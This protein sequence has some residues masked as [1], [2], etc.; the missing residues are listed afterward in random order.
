MLLKPM[1]EIFDLLDRP[2]AN[3]EAVAAY[4]RA[5]NPNIAIEVKT[6]SAEK[7]S[8]DF[9]R[10]TI[11]GTNGE[12][13]G[14]DAPTFGIIGRLGGIGARPGVTGFVSDGDGAL[15]ALT[16]AAKLSDMAAKGDR[17]PGDVRIATH[18]CPNAPIIPHD[19]VPFMGSPVGM[20]IMNR[21]EIFGRMDAI[22]AIDTTRGNRIINHRGIAISNTVKSGYILKVSDDLVRI[23]EITTGELAHVFPLATQDI[24]PYGNGLTH[25]NSIL[26]PATATDSPVVGLAITAQ[27]AVPGCGTGA[28]QPQD[29]EQAARYAVEVAKAFTAGKCAFYD[30]D[31]YDL[32]VKLYGSMAHLQK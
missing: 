23:L 24:T 16:A 8:T 25:L 1:I 22:L 10:I 32:L 7:G 27:T 29:V 13:V 26:Q 28:C 12:T 5:L 6:I 20:V 4:F 15:A 3:G 14:G 30:A 17:L 18:V 21:E 2:D 19:P 9:V 11:P 31:E